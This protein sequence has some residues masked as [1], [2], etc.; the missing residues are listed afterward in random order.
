[1]TQV[2]NLRDEQ[3][4]LLI[5]RPSKWGNPFQIGRDGNRERVITMYEIH[6]RRR[7][8]LIAALPELTGKRLG[9]YCHG[10]IAQESCNSRLNGITPWDQA[11]I[12]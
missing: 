12:A 4:D 9:C 7:P 10:I 6:I 11:G 8:D 1:M 2:I 5:C 3:C